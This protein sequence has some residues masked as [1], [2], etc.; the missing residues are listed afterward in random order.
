[1]RTSSLSR[2][3]SLTRNWGDDHDSQGKDK[4]QGKVLSK[5]ANLIQ[6]SDEEEEVQ[7]SPSPD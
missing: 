3:N 2:V 7:W 4:H 1:M 5:G 6:D